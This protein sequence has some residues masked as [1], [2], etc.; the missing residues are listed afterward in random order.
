MFRAVV[1][2]LVTLP[3][4]MP[5]GM[6]I[7]QFVPI[8][9]THAGP[10]PVRTVSHDADAGRHCTCVTCQTREQ[11]PSAGEQSRDCGHPARPCGD[12]PSPPVPGKHWPGCPA[13]LGTAPTKMVVAPATVPVDV[14]TGLCFTDPLVGPGILVRRVNSTPVPAISPP[15]Y[16][17]HCALLI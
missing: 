14:G 1:T 16:L 10:L 13:A 2:L 3:M 11:D 7:C 12:G 4:L 9:T 6:C 5:P 15:L 8:G 17:S